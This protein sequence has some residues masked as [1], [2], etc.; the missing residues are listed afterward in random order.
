MSTLSLTLQNLAPRLLANVRASS[1]PGQTDPAQQ[2]AQA[3]ELLREPLTKLAG[4]T[5]FSSLMS[6]ALM[7]AQRQAPALRQW[8]VGADGALECPPQD[9][10]AAEAARQ[11]GALLLS[12]LL[13]L[14][15]TFIGEPLTLRL[16]REAWP[17]VETLAPNMEAQR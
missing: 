3:C 15:V 11:G 12:E 5:G 9:P 6:R 2:A 13:G 16:V 10:Q 17:E 1:S 8:R 7:I 14:L 4:A